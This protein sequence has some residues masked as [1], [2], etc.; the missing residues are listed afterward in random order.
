MF[1][2]RGEELDR[3]HAALGRTIADEQIELVTLAGDVG[4]GKTRLAAHFAVQAREQGA[5]VLYGRAD[6][7]AL[8][9][10]SRLPRRFATTS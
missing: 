9:P 8:I 5:V 1:V 4:I 7:D 10:T 3:L 6:E 2:G